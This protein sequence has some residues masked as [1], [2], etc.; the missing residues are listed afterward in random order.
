M[1]DAG[2]ATAG[3]LQRVLDAAGAIRAAVYD[4]TTENPNESSLDACL[5]IWRNEGCDGLIAL[6]G[7]SP[8]DPSKALA[9]IVSHGG[10]FADYVVGTRGSEKIGHVAPQIA[11]PTAAG[12]GA[13]VGRACVMTL[14]DGRKTVAVN[15]DLVADTVICD[16]ELTL[17]LPPRLTA[18]TGIDALSHGI[19]TTLS[20]AEKPP[21][22][23]IALGCIG[24]AS[25][26]L[27]V[28]VDDG[29]NR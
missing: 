17:S 25:R 7:G 24:R 8:I 10:N 3:I 21:A 22:A 15:L 1:T 6:G 16:P 23:A 5:A 29:A 12:T 18:A 27:R 14:C 2:I 13:E 19:E 9:L 4:G 11:I 20:P 26:W 28:A